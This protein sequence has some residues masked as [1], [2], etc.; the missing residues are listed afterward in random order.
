MAEPIDLPKPLH[1]LLVE[2]NPDDARLSHEWLQ[3]ADPGGF[4]VRNAA[5]LAEAL[6]S[7]AEQVF[8]LVVL[9]LRLP[10]SQGLAGLRQL[11][12]VAPELPVVV[13]TNGD[14]EILRA[15]A[16]AAGA[17]D[18]LVKGH[19]KPEYWLAH[20]LRYAVERYRLQQQSNTESA[21][22]RG[23]RELCALDHLGQPATPVTASLYGQK[24]LADYD[25]ALFQTLTKTYRN[26]LEQA[27]EQQIY[28]VEYAVSRELA[29]LAEQLGFLKAGPRDVIDLHSQALE[30][31]LLESSRCAARFYTDEGR[32]MALELMG[33]LVS[34]YKRS[35]WDAPRARI[36]GKENP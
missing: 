21:R 19:F 22:A 11:Q 1:I 13:L 2:N 35:H 25:P 33:H 26:L 6:R 31:A 4:E 24:A 30:T 32:L 20:A 10:D 3:D 7:L 27:V 36:T 5:T 14:N 16:I 15:Q 34:Y 28:K 9:D 29:T 12:R 17:Q 23:V 18:Y 8:D